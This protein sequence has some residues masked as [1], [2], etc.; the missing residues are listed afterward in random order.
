MSLTICESH[1]SYPVQLG[2]YFNEL[3]IR[4]KAQ[5]ADYESRSSQEQKS[6]GHLK[7]LIEKK[8]KR[9]MKLEDSHAQELSKKDEERILAVQES[10]KEARDEGYVA[11]YEM[12]S[13]DALTS[14]Q[15]YEE[16]EEIQEDSYKLAISH[17][18]KRHPEWD[19]AGYYPLMDGPIPMKNKEKADMD[20][21]EV[22]P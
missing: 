1:F 18:S 16:M 9:I 8:D 4:H 20:E 3:G 14:D 17:V 5:V 11:G 2:V 7:K 6:I 21:D 22:A 10:K 15:Y 13:K 19:F 12:G